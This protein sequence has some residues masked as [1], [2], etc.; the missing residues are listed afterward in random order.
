LL[1]FSIGAYAF[2]EETVTFSDLE[3]KGLKYYKKGSA[4]EFSGRIA[5]TE[6]R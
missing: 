2:L 6:K 5:G 4:K 1:I 3:E